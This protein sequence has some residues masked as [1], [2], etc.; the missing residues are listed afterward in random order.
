MVKTYKELLKEGYKG[1]R[2]WYGHWVRK[3]GRVM[4][5]IR[6]A[7]IL[8]GYAS[9][10]SGKRNTPEEMEAQRSTRVLYNIPEDA[11]L[12]EPKKGTLAKK[13]ADV[14]RPVVNPI[15]SL[16]GG[17]DNLVLLNKTVIPASIFLA[18]LVTRK[19][20]KELRRLWPEIKY[21][22][23]IPWQR[24]RLIKEVKD[25]L[26]NQF[27]SKFGFETI[28]RTFAWVKENL[29][30]TIRWV[31]RNVQ[32]S[33]YQIVPYARPI[34]QEPEPEMNQRAARYYN[35]LQHMHEMGAFANANELRRAYIRFSRLYHPDKP[36]GSHDQFIALENE[37]KMLL[38]QYS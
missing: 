36:G 25:Q 21:M 16:V 6:A 24:E 2:P 19:E 34:G 14:L 22:W 1:K 12:K 18:Y 5:A 8:D 33:Q 23:S 17:M 37:Y 26:Y 35:D 3:S 32:P 30:E 11:Y 15:A 13:A 10:R 31:R 28:R 29:T 27:A 4:E 9:Y 20:F 38:Q 7:H